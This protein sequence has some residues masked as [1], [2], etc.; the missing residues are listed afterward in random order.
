MRGSLPA[1][2]YAL[3]V[4]ATTAVVALAST[5]LRLGPLGIVGGAVLGC[6]WSLALGRM[7][8]RA[9]RRARWHPL[10]ADGSVFLGIILI[11]PMLGGGVMYELLMQAAAA[12]AP[13]AVL[14]AMMQPTIPFFIALN[15]P[16]ELFVIPAALF[17]NWYNDA[18]RRPIVIAAATFYVLR[19]WSYL[20][21]VQQRLAIASR[22]L[23]ADDLEWFQRSLAADYRPLL[24]AIVLLAFTAAAFVPNSF[25]EI[26]GHR[27]SPTD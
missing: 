9:S 25:G 8:D 2:P 1:S 11:G 12:G 22:P 23:T 21:Y 3:I 17:A 15:T 4:P 20:T 16:L 19:T 10:I 13:D 14:S 26:D 24:V 6:A 7:I 5:G 27:A 18:R